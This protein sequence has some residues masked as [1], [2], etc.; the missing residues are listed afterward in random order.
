MTP[1]FFSMR[2]LS[3]LPGRL[4]G[5][6]LS[7]TACG[8]LLLIAG[9][10]GSGAG[11]G[12]NG[13]NTGP[14]GGAVAG[15]ASITLTAT[16]VGT[17]EVVN[18]ISANAPAELK[19]L[20]R[21]ASGNPVANTVVAFSATDEDK[22]AFQPAH[23]AL[24]NASGM[25]SVVITPAGLTSGGAQTVSAEATVAGK[26][27]SGSHGL[28]IGV[29]DVSVEKLET[30]LPTGATAVPAY[31]TTTVKATVSR[32][33]VPV[34]VS[35]ASTCV[36]AGRAELTSQAQTVNGVAVATYT[37]KGCSGTDRITAQVVGQAGTATT[38]V[39]VTPPAIANVQFVSATPTTIALAGTGATTL[40]QTSTVTFRVVDQAGNPVPTPI[41]VDFRLS[42]STGGILLD[43]TAQETIRKQ[44]G[45]DG[46]VQVRVRAG[47]I[48]TP[49]WVE[50]ALPDYPSVSPTQSNRL[51]ISTGRPAQARFSLSASVLNINGWGYDG[52]QSVITVYAADRLGNPVADGTVVNFVSEGA[53][54]EP[55]C[56]TTNGTCAVNL[57]SQLSRPQA[58]AGNNRSDTGRVTVVAY[59]IGE[60]S[61]LDQNANNVWDPSE[62]FED[63]GF[64]YI[65]PLE[66]RPLETGWVDGGGS[67]TRSRAQVI[68]FVTAQ[69]QDKVCAAPAVGA[70][71]VPDT[72][73]ATWGAAHVRRDLVIV[74]S[75]EAPSLKSAIDPDA[76]EIGRAATLSPPGCAAAFNFALQ[77]QHGNP[78]PAGTTLSADVGSAKDVQASVAGTP[79]PSTTRR[80]GT[81][82]QLYVMGTFD[83]ATGLCKGSGLVRLN[84]TTPAPGNL[85]TTLG[86]TVAPA[87][88]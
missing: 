47:T 36:A 77:D 16:K 61:F 50:A 87:A 84:V 88:P 51:T 28:S 8:A 57:R 56:S 41:S 52:V 4:R 18:S 35:F 6:A 75:G 39:V 37:D 69:L 3:P 7:L 9:C 76:P 5:L 65:D 27:L 32:T 49:V 31:G 68:P 14:T 11:A 73:D 62:P 38:D 22:V 63:L 20:V 2:S 54:V 80:G 81:A 83:D 46:T 59:A 79:V 82:G 19:A 72:C 53:S 10:G 67:W 42:T 74:L 29:V 44:T 71:S 21:D 23:T 58:T 55:S 48:P 78:M 1:R 86:F 15:D 85:Q 43:N 17:N 45:G 24:T 60:E 40:E 64:V 30:V 13:F 66:N 33:A 26:L 70:P 12:G 25:A 34:T